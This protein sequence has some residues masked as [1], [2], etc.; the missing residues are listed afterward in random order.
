VLG[1]LPLGGGR[2]GHH[3]HR[4]RLT[5]LLAQ[6]AELDVRLQ[7]FGGAGQGVAALR[8]G[9]TDLGQHPARGVVTDGLQRRFAQAEAV[10]CNQ[11]AGVH[12]QDPRCPQCCAAGMSCPC[13]AREE[14]L[15]SLRLRLI[16]Q[17]AGSPRP[18]RRPPVA[19]RPGA[20]S[21]R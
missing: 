16:W 5:L 11:G 1:K 18:R 6:A 21:G 17:A 10:G 4:L 3:R 15:P 14:A 19:P 13:L 7:P 2:A 12:G 8:I 20:A 9:R